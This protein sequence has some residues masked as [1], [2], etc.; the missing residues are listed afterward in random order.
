MV[1]GRKFPS[2]T[3]QHVWQD[4]LWGWGGLHILRIPDQH[5]HT[6]THTQ[7]GLEILMCQHQNFVGRTRYA[8]SMWVGVQWSS[9]WPSWRMAHVIPNQQR[10]LNKL[11]PELRCRKFVNMH[12]L[13][14]EIGTKR[15][16]K[17]C[18]QRVR[19]PPELPFCIPLL[20]VGQKLFG[21]IWML[22]A[23]ASGWVRRRTF[24]PLHRICPRNAPSYIRPYYALRVGRAIILAPRYSRFFSWEHQAS[25]WPG[26]ATVSLEKKNYFQDKVQYRMLLYAH[27]FG[28]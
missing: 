16:K 20:V 5:T 4:A 27:F 14:M 19:I 28:L 26:I 7:D 11:P 2:S 25:G 3:V 21:Q 10:T 6:H 18:M 17:P 1:D 12:R 13:S 24:L 22:S 8:W 23:H 9:T 15:A